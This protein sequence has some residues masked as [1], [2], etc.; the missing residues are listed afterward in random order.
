MA[1]KF[2]TELDNLKCETVEMAHFGRAMLRDAVDGLIRQDKV[3]AESVV[4]R[5]EEI[6]IME[7]RLEEHCYQLIALN[8][9]MAKD[10]RVIACT[11]KVITASLRIGRYGKV[12]ANI[13][14]EVADNPHIANLMSIPHM[15]ELVIEM[16]DDAIQAYETDNLRLIDAFSSR[17]DTIDALRHS[18]F[19]QG[20]TYMME[21][22][23]TISR[24]THYIMVAR[25][26]ERCADHACKIAENVQ[27]METGERVEIH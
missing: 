5:K 21:D 3:L 20:I 18:I 22:P 10:M 26:L 15:A 11:L 6:H 9:P 13:V 23:R 2:H 24:C 27:Y 17:D 12:I 8:Q 4:A 14:K 7:V 1:E 16:I 19:R 25:Y